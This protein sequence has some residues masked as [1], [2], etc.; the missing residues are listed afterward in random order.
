[1][2]RVHGQR[3]IG[4]AEGGDDA[5]ADRNSS[6]GRGG[7]RE[8]REGTVGGPEEVA[9]SSGWVNLSVRFPASSKDGS[10]G[11]PAGNRVLRGTGGVR[12]I[13]RFG[14]SA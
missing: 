4:S 13:K 3:V 1:M 6:P 12:D 5:R 14:L 7:P 9:L 10:S 11:G 2:A 8:K